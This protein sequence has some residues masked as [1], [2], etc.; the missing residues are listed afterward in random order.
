MGPIPDVCSLGQERADDVAVIGRMLPIVD[1]PVTTRQLPRCARLLHGTDK[2]A[3]PIEGGA[4]LAGKIPIGANARHRPLLLFK[5]D[6]RHALAES[7]HRRTDAE[8]RQAEDT[9]VRINPAPQH[10]LRSPKVDPQVTVLQ[11]GHAVIADE[12][13]LG[14]RHIYRRGL[15]EEQREGEK[16]HQANYITL[17]ASTSNV[18]RRFFGSGR[19]AVIQRQPQTTSDTRV[20]RSVICQR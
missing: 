1:V 20:D 11:K 2:S 12:I 10:R 5:L 7:R 4:E 8:L 19:A 9:S 18:A 13:R 15:G 6:A 16:N 17:K 14:P 3:L